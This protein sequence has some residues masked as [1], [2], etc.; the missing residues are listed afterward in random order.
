MSAQTKQ[1]IARFHVCEKTGDWCIYNLRGMRQDVKEKIAR[2]ILP[3]RAKQYLLA[4]ID[5]LPQECIGARVDGYETT[6]LDP[7]DHQLTL[8]TNTTVV[9][10]K[11]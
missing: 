6:F 11:L 5:I 1:D 7:N 9:G 8:A 4:K 2:S 10:I 3:D